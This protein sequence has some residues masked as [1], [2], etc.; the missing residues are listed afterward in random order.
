MRELESASAWGTQAARTE[1]ASEDELEPPLSFEELWNL[2]LEAE[3]KMKNRAGPQVESDTEPETDAEPVGSGPSGMGLEMQVGPFERRRAVC[4]GAG[5]CSLG[6]WAPWQRPVNDDEKLRK[7]YELVRETVKDL[8]ALTGHTAKQL[9]HRLAKGDVQQD[10][11]DKGKFS[12]VIRR[13]KQ[14]FPGAHERPTDQPQKIAIRFLEAALHAAGDPDR[15]GMRHFCQGVR[16]GVNRKLP[17]VPAVFARK[18]KWR[19]AEQAEAEQY[20]GTSTE[21]A[22]REN[23]KS[24][25]VHVDLIEEQLEDH[26]K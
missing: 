22:W 6:K 18:K 17:R 3:E 13:A 4:D 26:A 23:Y 19:L 5:L 10:P 11:F 16:L 2:G 8:P 15:N 14:L 7:L 24:V 12:Q 1:T 21:G 20:Y 25:K 9:F